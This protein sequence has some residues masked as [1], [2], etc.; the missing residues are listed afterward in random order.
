MMRDVVGWRLKLWTIP[1]LAR[2][3]PW[4]LLDIPLLRA[5]SWQPGIELHEKIDDAYQWF[6]CHTK[7][8]RGARFERKKCKTIDGH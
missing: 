7:D 8:F 1:A 3:T 4:K 5:L 6:R 2:G